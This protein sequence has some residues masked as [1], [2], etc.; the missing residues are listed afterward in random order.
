MFKWNEFVIPIGALTANG[1]EL[2]EQIYT[3]PESNFENDK[4]ATAAIAGFSLNGYGYTNCSVT[5][6]A[7][8]G[9]YIIYSIKN[10]GSTNLSD[11]KLKVHIMFTLLNG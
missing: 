6:C 10:I 8:I 9:K 1:G 5:S 3:I 4:W 2:Y 7:V 11:I